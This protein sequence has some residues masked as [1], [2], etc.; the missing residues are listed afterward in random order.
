MQKILLVDVMK[1]ESKRRPRFI[2]ELNLGQ[3][4]S[5][6]L[7]TTPPFS[8][9]SAS[10]PWRVKSNRAPIYTQSTCPQIHSPTNTATFLHSTQSTHSCPTNSSHPS[11]ESC[12][13]AAAL[14]AWCWASQRA[15][16]H[17]NR[18]VTL[19]AEFPITIP[20]NFIQPSLTCRFLWPILTMAVSTVF[21]GLGRPSFQVS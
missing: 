19:R 12:E 11:Q 3:A 13:A 10:A 14:Q 2:S 5:T 9:C 1:I 15:T 6:Y 8:A 21:W 7:A 17:L 18:K 4:D 20:Q 16:N